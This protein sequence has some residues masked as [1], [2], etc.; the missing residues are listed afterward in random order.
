VRATD[1]AGNLGPYSSVATAST[2]L[3]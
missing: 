1:A 2:L 3:F